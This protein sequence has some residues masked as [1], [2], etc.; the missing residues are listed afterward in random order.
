MTFSN[1]LPRRK[2]R[3]IKRKFLN[4]PRGGEFTLVRR[5]RIKKLI[6]PLIF[7]MAAGFYAAPGCRGEVVVLDLVT[8]VKTPIRITV[9]TKGRFFSAGGRLVDI[10]L[11]D[12]HL[13]RILTGGDGYGYF[14]YT[15]RSPGYKKIKASSNSDSAEALL[16]VMAKKDRALAIEVE[17][18]FKTAIFSEEIKQSSLRVLKT[19]SKKYKIIYLS[20]YVGKRITG[21][22]IEK[23]GF[24]KSVI[25]GWQGAGT[26]TALKEKGIQLHAIIGSAAVISEAAGDIQNRFTFEKTKDGTTV[27]DWDEILEHLQEK[28]E[29]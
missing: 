11:D 26:L 12:E 7:C 21:A 28:H 14:K 25:L 29:P 4:A 16:L 2:Q 17:E 13:K 3:G 6:L 24:P 8:T 27:K 23:Q 5:R 22:W 19:L 10:F 1:E 15:P 18:G 20:R 9:L